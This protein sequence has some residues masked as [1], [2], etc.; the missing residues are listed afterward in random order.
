MIR[1]PRPSG[2]LRGRAQTD[3][4]GTLHLEG[5]K[6]RAIDTG[7]ARLIVA[8]AIFLLAF[9]VIAG[10]MVDVTI[11]RDGGV[12][13]A[14]QAH[15]A[16]SEVGRADIVDRNGVPA[17]HQPA[18]RSLYAH[19]HEI[20]DPA[21]AARAI[22][23]VLPELAADEIKAKLASDRSF[24]YLKRN[25]TPTAG[26]RRQRAGHSGPLFREGQQARL[27]RGRAGRPCRRP[28]RS[29]RQGHRRHREV[30]RR[31]ARRPP[32]AAA[33]VARH[34]RADRAARR[35]GSRPRPSSTRSAPPEW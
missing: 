6:K 18:D 12:P 5:V 34:P 11:L 31:G 33:S 7:R 1:L 17:G 2:L 13:R 9:S 15:A 24:L 29:R 19:P 8:G 23:G 21:G 35:A 14:Q 28:D 30:V 10:R 20:Q 3:V 22:A 26:L 4:S 27:S 16:D 32:R 25:L